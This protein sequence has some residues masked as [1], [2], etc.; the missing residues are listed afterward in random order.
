[1]KLPSQASHIWKMLS[2]LFIFAGVMGVFSTSSASYYQT[3]WILRCGSSGTATQ[4]LMPF[5]DPWALHGVWQIL[6][7]E[8]PFL[9]LGPRSDPAFVKCEEAMPSSLSL[10]KFILF[11]LIRYFIAWFHSL[12]VCGPHF[13]WFLTVEVLDK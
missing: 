13:L 8:L 2:L 1:M 11:S 4:P 7:C 9:D 5:W 12:L 10:T 3:F 6:S